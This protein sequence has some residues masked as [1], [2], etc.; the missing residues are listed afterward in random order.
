VKRQGRPGERP[1]RDLENTTTPYLPIE[2]PARGR[3]DALSALVNA[4]LR[5]AAGT[6]AAN[7][8]PQ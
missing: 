2:R 5:R 6:A 4:L 3:S 7:R 1:G 8:L